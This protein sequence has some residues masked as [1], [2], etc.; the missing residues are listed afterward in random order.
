MLTGLKSYFNRVYQRSKSLREGRRRT[1]YTIRH[2]SDAMNVTWLTIENESGKTMLHWRDVIR[3]EAFKRDL[4]AV[5]LICLA[6]IVD[7]NTEVEIN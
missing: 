6:F 5:D 1:V 4:Y 3:V 7:E 2:D